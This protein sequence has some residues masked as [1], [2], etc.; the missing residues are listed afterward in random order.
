MSCD[1]QGPI[2]IITDG[3]FGAVG[4][5][6]GECKPANR[7]ARGVSC[8][9]LEAASYPPPGAG[10]HAYSPIAVFQHFECACDT[11]VA[12]GI[13]VACVHN[14]RSG[15]ERPIKAD[16]VIGGGS[17]PAAVVA[18]RRRGDGYTFPDE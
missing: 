1:R 7:L 16:G 8:L 5:G 10:F 18:I 9:T 12:R 3:Y 14:P 15:Q 11:E 4:Q 6:G 2:V 17:A 13:E